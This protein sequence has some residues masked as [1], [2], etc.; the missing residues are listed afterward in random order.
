MAH[1]HEGRD[2]LQVGSGDGPHFSIGVDEVLPSGKRLLVK[3][4]GDRTRVHAPR[5][6]GELKSEIARSCIVKVKE[7]SNA[8]FALAFGHKVVLAVRISVADHVCQAVHRGDAMVK[9]ASKLGELGSQFFS[10]RWS[11]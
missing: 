7:G 2:R 11:R 9:T 1:G 10:H 4:P 6:N 3:L 8:L 5:I